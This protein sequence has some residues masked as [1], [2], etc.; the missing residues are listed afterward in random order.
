MPIFTVVCFGR[1]MLAGGG[2]TPPQQP[3]P[4]SRC[5]LIGVLRRG[6]SA[7][8]VTGHFFVLLLAHELLA[9][10]AAERA[11]VARLLCGTARYILDNGLVFVDPVPCPLPPRLALSGR[12]FAQLPQDACPTS[13]SRSVYVPTTCRGPPHAPSACNDSL[14]V[15][16]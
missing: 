4:A 10:T 11:R 7:Q 15:C 5:G 16:V 13:T 2:C 8:E 3:L 14:P 1:L 12:A 9:R 6:R